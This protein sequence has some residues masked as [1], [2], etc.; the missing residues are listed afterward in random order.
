[1]YDLDRA[2][3]F[4]LGRVHGLT[5]QQLGVAVSRA[6]AKLHNSLKKRVTLS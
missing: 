4:V 3:V 5:R 1:M 6:G 2:S